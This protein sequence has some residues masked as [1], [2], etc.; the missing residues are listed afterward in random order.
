[1]SDFENQGRLVEVLRTLTGHRNEIEAFYHALLDLQVTNHNRD[2]LLRDAFACSVSERRGA[3]LER[4]QEA[5]ADFD[6]SMTDL[7]ATLGREVRVDA[8]AAHQ[9][10]FEGLCTIRNLDQKIAAMFLKFVVVY[11]RQWPK[12][13]RHLFIPIDTVVL[14]ILRYRLQVYSGRWEQSPS[15]KNA[16][17]DLYVE[18]GRQPCAHYRRFL[19][20]QEELEDI[21]K[22]ANVHR[23]LVDELWF[24][25]YVFCK[26]YPLCNRCWIR[27]WCQSPGP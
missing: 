16:Q 11:L 27:Q 19:Q 8:A 4:G 6:D 22:K 7:F 24:V 26:E 25:G 17:G 10:L 21:C 2:Q 20:F 5:V 15:V 12:L 23:I 14:K 13:E 9:H 18:N 1:V 3:S